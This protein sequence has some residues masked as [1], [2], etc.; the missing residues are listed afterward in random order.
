ML[1][2]VLLLTGCTRFLQDKGDGLDVNIKFVSKECYM[3]FT[4]DDTITK[5]TEDDELKK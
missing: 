4:G 2:S 5:Q 1:I 3:E